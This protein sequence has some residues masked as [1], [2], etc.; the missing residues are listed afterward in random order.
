MPFCKSDSLFFSLPS[1]ITVSLPVSPGFRFLYY[2]S[3]FT[4]F[5]HILPAAILNAP[6]FLFQCD[7]QS[8]PRHSRRTAA[9][10]DE[11]PPHILC[12]A[13]TDLNLHRFTL[14]QHLTTNAALTETPLLHQTFQQAFIR[15]YNTNLNLANVH[16]RRALDALDSMGR[17][18]PRMYLRNPDTGNDDPPAPPLSLHF[19]HPALC[20]RAN[21]SLFRQRS[22]IISLLF[23]LE[24]GSSN[25]IPHRPLQHTL[26]PT[27]LSKQTSLTHPCSTRNSKPHHVPTSATSRS[28]LT[29]NLSKLRPFKQTFTPLYATLQLLPHRTLPLFPLLHLLQLH[30]SPPRPFPPPALHRSQQAAQP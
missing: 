17:H 28:K 7:S 14:H 9:V 20:H 21:Q 11:D 15:N 27:P 22:D 8:W 1:F 29:M 25:T 10:Y 24:H 23:N 19:P 18:P 3:A 16:L 4:S 5:T 6:P 30:F 12:G 26:P 13:L 2:A